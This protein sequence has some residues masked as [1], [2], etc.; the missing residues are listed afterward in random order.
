MN[1]KQESFKITSISRD[2]FKSEGYDCSGLSDATMEHIASKMADAYC[3]CCF[4]VE[5]R[6]HAEDRELPP[7]ITKKCVKCNDHETMTDSKYCWDH[8]MRKK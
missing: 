1:N 6:F 5:L 4:W 8:D 2:D 7:L 3:E